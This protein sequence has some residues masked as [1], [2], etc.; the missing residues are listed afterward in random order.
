[1]ERV[2]DR[3]AKIDPRS[4]ANFSVADVLTTDTPRTY[5]WACTTNLD[6]GS[7]GACVGFG[8][9]HELAARPKVHPV[10]NAT[11]H[12]LY[13]AAQRLDEWTGGEYPGATPTYSGSSVTGGAKAVQAENLLGEYRWAPDLNNALVA[14]SHTGPAVIGINWWTGMFNPDSN[15]YLHPTGRIEGGH[16]ILVRG[17]SLPKRAVLFHNSWGASWGGTVKGPGTAWVSFDDFAKLMDDQG[18]VCIP[19]QRR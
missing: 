10:T 3:I 7:E 5:T 14:I 9:S 1:M 13:Y 12:D 17:V 8:W 19:V 4:L 6:Q 2:L 11:A 15:G 16:C 18:E